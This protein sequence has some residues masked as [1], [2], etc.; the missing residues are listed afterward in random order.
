MAGRS[1]TLRYGWIHGDAAEAWSDDRDAGAESTGVVARDAAR[2]IQEAAEALL[3]P[4]ERITGHGKCWA[5]QIHDRV[6]LIFRARR[7]Y[8]LA[9]TD[10]RMLVFERTRRGPTP[11]DLVLGKRYETFTL[12]RVKRHRPLLQV[13]FRGSNGARMV[14]EFRRGQRE[15]A[16]ELI[17]RLTPR[18]PAMPAP[19]P[20]DEA[21]AAAFWGP[22]SR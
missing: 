21:V 3:V 16:G 14:F 8:L 20:K 5:A 7:E 17:A 10:R 13:S 4:G 19:T 12:E 11:R 1:L 15:V 18:E 2:R 9:L 6:P 22:P